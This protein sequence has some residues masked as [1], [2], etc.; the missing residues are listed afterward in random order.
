MKNIT[1]KDKN[2]CFEWETYHDDH[3]ITVVALDAT[4]EDFKGKPTMINGKPEVYF[5]ERTVKDCTNID[6]CVY[7][8]LGHVS[9]SIL[10]DLIEKFD[11]V[12]RKLISAKK[13]GNKGRFFIKQDAIV[14]AHRKNKNPLL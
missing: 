2:I 1:N 6:G 9:D 13:F 5:K 11:N 4:L 8:H 14:I 12:R 3:D 7:F 10:V